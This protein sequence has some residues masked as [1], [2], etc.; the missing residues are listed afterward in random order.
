MKAQELRAQREWTEVLFQS[1][2]SN[3]EVHRQFRVV[4]GGPGEHG[5]HMAIFL[6]GN[7]GRG[8]GQRDSSP[9]S[10]PSPSLPLPSLSGRV[11][12]KTLAELFRNQC[13]SG[14]CIHSPLHLFTLRD[15]T[16]YV[17]YL[18]EHGGPSTLCVFAQM[19]AG[20]GNGALI[21]SVGVPPR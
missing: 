11:A 9:A 12:Q 4:M 3:Q 20:C 6:I 15:R 19:V 1:S 14:T 21:D 18:G 16:G 2:W 5:P 13:C 8:M 7:G 17:L 10:W